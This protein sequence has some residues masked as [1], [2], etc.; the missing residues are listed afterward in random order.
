MTV[1]QP[2]K[3]AVQ[4]RCRGEATFGRNLKA[5]YGDSYIVQDVSFD[6]AEGEIIALLGRNG[7][8]KTSTLRTI[9]RADRRSAQWRDLAPRASRYTRCSPIR[10]PISAFSWCRKTAASFPA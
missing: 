7:A 1:A 6:M 4:P 10:Q 5:Y 8:G 2:Q 9:A 3:R